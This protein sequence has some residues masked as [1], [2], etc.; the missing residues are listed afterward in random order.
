MEGNGMKRNHDPAID[1]L[2]FNNI[3]E[4][5]DDRANWSLKKCLKKQKRAL[6]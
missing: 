4:I 6:T 2:N 3:I 1:R 5:I